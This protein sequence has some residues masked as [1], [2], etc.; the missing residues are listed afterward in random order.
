MDPE[1]LPPPLRRQ[2]LQL[3][4]PMVVSGTLEAIITTSPSTDLLL[5]MAAFTVGPMPMVEW[6]RYPA[7]ISTMG[8][9]VAVSL[10]INIKAKTLTFILFFRTEVSQMSAGC[11]MA[12]PTT[13]KTP[14]MD[15]K[16]I[17]GV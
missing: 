11:Q 5:S 6:V 3:S 7:A 4:T 14:N 1:L 13:T 16:G 8:V 17:R 9:A 2:L 12:V 15:P 10:P